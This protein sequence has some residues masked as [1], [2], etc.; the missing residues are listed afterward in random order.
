V[1]LDPTA[2]PR[3]APHADWLD[4]DGE[5]VI[6]DERVARIRVLN[7]AGSL[8]WRLLDGTATIEEVVDDLVSV[9]ELEHA[10]VETDVRRLVAELHRGGLLTT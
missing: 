7:P 2:R 1:S 3:P 8:V 10:T 5:V 6:Y 4:L 9:L